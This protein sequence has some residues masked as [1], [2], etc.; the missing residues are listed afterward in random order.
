MAAKT[1]SLRAA[2]QLVSFAAFL[3][4]ALTGGLGITSQG[5][6]ACK[7]RRKCQPPAP[8]LSVNDVSR[9]EG[10][11]GQT[12]F[13]FTVSLSSSSSANVS[14][15]YATADGTATAPSDYAAASGTLTVPAGQTSATV[16]VAVNGDTAVEPDETFSLNLSSPSGATVA[17]GSGVGTILNDDA[18][19]SSTSGCAQDSV[20]PWSCSSLWYTPLPANP[21]VDP[22]SAQ[23]IQYWLGNAVKWPNVSIHKYGTAV[24]VADPTSPLYH[25][26]CTTYACPNL[27]QFGDVPI[28]LGT[29][30][31]P[32]SDGKLAV[33]DPASH[34]E[35]D[36]WIS[37]C[38]NDCG[39]TATGASWSTDGSGVG[40][41]YGTNAA[42]FP[43]LA[44][45]L[46]PEDFQRGHID[47]ALRFS[48]VGA[49]VGHVCPAT[50]DDGNSSDAN[51]LPEGT[52]LQLDPTLNVGALD[53]PA[54]QKVFAK[55]LQ[56]YGAYLTDKGGSLN[57]P[58]ENPV[59][60]GSDPWDAVGMSG[61]APGFASNF[62]WDKM[63][64]LLPPKPWC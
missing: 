10:N 12:T 50:H 14:V 58:A 53:L 29:Q 44:G 24:A 21:A 23:K 8:S 43:E 48:E 18:S 5:A 63:R 56:E 13:T 39:S 64:V 47:H 38:P 9:S 19:S 7:P 61:D 27:L 49:K 3:P 52:L 46:R 35:W 57:F 30:P 11:S 51:A 40:A 16:A 55:A 62:P 22:A 54:W 25:V 2:L 15:S 6:P 45:L 28:P 4:S 26:T 32:S 31:D 37:K 17:D 41:P 36:F 33:W 42:N 20:R 59:N 34:H 1:K 60:R